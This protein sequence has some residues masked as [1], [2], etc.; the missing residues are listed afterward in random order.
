M[1]NGDDWLAPDKLYHVLFC[2]FIAITV[3]SLAY[4]TRYPFLRRWSIWLGS[5]VSLFAGVAKEAG[6]EIGIWESAGASVKDVI[7]DLMGIFMSLVVLLL[8]K[9]VSLRR[10]SE[11]LTRSRGVSMV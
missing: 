6:D 8:V 10:K 9:S 7:A 5:L 1:E 4:R 11:E 2:F 3:A